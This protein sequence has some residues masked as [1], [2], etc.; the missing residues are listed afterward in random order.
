MKHY[1]HEFKSSNNED[2]FHLP[3]DGDPNTNRK[4]SKIAI[5]ERRYDIKWGVVNSGNAIC[6]S[7]HDSKKE[8]TEWKRKNASAYEVV[9]VAVTPLYARSNGK[10]PNNTEKLLI[11]L[12]R[13]HETYMDLLKK[14]SK[15]ELEWC[16]LS[17]VRCEYYE[18]LRMAFEWGYALER[19]YGMDK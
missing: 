19:K 5:S 7:V 14:D 15:G 12:R 18:A 4:M 11:E 8:A 3:K 17:P 13:K 16:E 10:E 9:R 1:Y 2:C 6:L